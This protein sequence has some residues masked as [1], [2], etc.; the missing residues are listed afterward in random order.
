[1]SIQKVRLAKMS[2]FDCS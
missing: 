2:M 1:M